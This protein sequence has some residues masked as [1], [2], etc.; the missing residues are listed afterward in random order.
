[1]LVKDAEGAMEMPPIKGDVEFKNVTFSYEDGVEILK[2]VSF[3]AKKG[4]TVADR[5][6]PV[7]Q[8]S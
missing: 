2:K 6:E 8:P 1:V 3:K 4:Q 5:Q 7:K